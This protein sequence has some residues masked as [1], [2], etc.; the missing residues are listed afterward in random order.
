MTAPQ[1]LSAPPGRLLSYARLMRLD[2]PTGNWLLLWPGVWA[3]M[4]ASDGRPPALTLI[5]MGLGAVL[6]RS[7]GCVVNDLT[8]RRLD[9]SV[10]R[11]RL[12]P[13]AAGHVSRREALALALIL[14]AF[15]GGLVL[16]LG[17]PTVICALA[18]LPLVAAYPWMKRITWWPQAFLGLTFNWGA[19]LGWVM[20]R[21]QIELPALLLYAGGIAWT[22]GY[23][24]IYAHQDAEDDAAAGIKSTAR[25][26]AHRSPLIVGICYLVALFFWTMAGIV[27]N[28][29]SLYNVALLATAWQFNWQLLHFKPEDPERCAMIFRSNTLI[30]W[31]LVLGLIAI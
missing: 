24:T 22:I 25:L 1:S 2:Q 19:L 4:M 16:P 11:T 17:Q 8:D 21:G 26:F 12:R 23:D 10:A 29:P 27:A 14:V 28:A 30:G 18:A 13:L 31:L 6:M 20:I 3:L 9:Q 15:A 5:V 7:A